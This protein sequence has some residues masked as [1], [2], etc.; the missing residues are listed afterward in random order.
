MG[1]R[2]LVV[3]VKQ[4]PDPAKLRM[5]PK[6]GLLVREGLETT[7]NPND[8]HAIEAAV[9]FKESITTEDAPTI[10]VLSMGPP[11]AEDALRE[12][13]ARGCDEAILITD[14]KFAGS[15]TFATSYVLSQAIKKLGDDVDVIFAGSASIDGDTG[16]VGPQTGEWLGIPQITYVDKIEREDGLITVERTLG[17]QLQVI[18]APY[19]I[20]LLTVLPQLNQP[21]Y[22]SY[23]R[24]NWAYEQPV[25]IWK[26]TDLDVDESMVGLAGSPTQ[27]TGYESVKQVRVGE[28]I[29]ERVKVAAKKIIEILQKK[30]VLEE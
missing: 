6:T 11:Q 1:N 24:V 20:V 27:I 30:Q 7:I 5:D 10:V 14:P 4:V 12:A 26:E 9:Q 18:Q 22:P 25:N 13:L 29:Q 19:P 3:L 17:H 8:L 23:V 21:R 16:Q 15:D 2:K 28:V